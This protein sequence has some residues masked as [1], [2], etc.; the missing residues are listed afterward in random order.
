LQLAEFKEY[1]KAHFDNGRALSFTAVERNVY[2]DATGQFAW[3]DEDIQM[4]L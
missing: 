4:T 2:V 3:F 1:A